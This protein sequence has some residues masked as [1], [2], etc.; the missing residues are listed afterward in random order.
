LVANASDSSQRF[1]CG[2]C[3]AVIRLTTNRP[4]WVRVYS[5]TEYQTADSS[6]LQTVDPTGEHGVILE[7]ITTA[8]NLSLDLCPGALVFSVEYSGLDT[9]PATVKNL[10]SVTG[11]VIVTLTFIRFEA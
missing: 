7:C 10:D 8:A 5:A 1:D 9:V 11:E 6:R 3:C 2:K 4:A